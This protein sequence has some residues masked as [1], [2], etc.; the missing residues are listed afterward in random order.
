MPDVVKCPHA[1][2]KLEKYPVRGTSEYVNRTTINLGWSA[3]ERGIIPVRRGRET[4]VE[5]RVLCE[6]E[7]F[8]VFV[9]AEVPKNL[10]QY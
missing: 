3:A 10:I 1:L 6:R 8:L 2:I 4:Y 9:M 5:A 7:T